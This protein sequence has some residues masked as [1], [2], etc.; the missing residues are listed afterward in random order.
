MPLGANQDWLNQL[1]SGSSGET[2]GLSGN[3]DVWAAIR[4]FLNSLG[5]PLPSQ[6]LQR[7]AGG[8]TGGGMQIG[9]PN[10]GGGGGGTPSAPVWTPVEGTP[11]AGGG[12]W[13]PYGFGGSTIKGGEIPGVPGSRATLGAPDPNAKVGDMTNAYMAKTAAEATARPPNGQSWWTT[14]S[15]M[16]SLVDPNTGIYHYELYTPEYEKAFV[17]AHPHR[18]GLGQR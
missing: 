9:P 5:I 10:F 11:I 2:R 13:Y 3:S 15:G 8:T 12:L 1:F 18:I 7:N 16:A 4:S 14:P 17:N 6:P